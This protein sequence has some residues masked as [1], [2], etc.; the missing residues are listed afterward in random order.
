MDSPSANPPASEAGFAQMSK[1]QKL[2]ALLILLGPETAARLLKGMDEPEMESIT[3]EMAKIGMLSLD[4]QHKVLQEFAELA[5]E[6]ST[7]VAGG[8]DLTHAALERALGSNKA[9]HIMSR[10]VPGHSSS[11]SLQQ[12]TE[13]EP[14]EIFTLVRQEQPQMIALILSYL[15]ADK[16]SAVL[17]KLGENLREDVLERLA[18]LAPTPI[19]VV[20]RLVDMLIG[21]LGNQNKAPLRQSGGVKTAA[22]LLN[23]LDRNLS[24]GLLTS[25]EER[26]PELGQAI[27]Q[28]MFTFED[29]AALDVGSLQKLLREVDTRDLATALKNSSEKVKSSVLGAISKRAAE[30]VREEIGLMGAL[31]ARDIEAAQRRIIEVVRRLESEGELELG[32]ATKK[33]EATV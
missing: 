22:D 10:L 11:A 28:K 21:K 17:A 9:S 8:I 29:V 3:V 24:K 15:S 30:T 6:A 31:K 14:S 19:E 18:T 4:T 27:R 12:L 20:E 23:A 5:V 2:A 13:L 32:D 7:A 1:L 33:D 16:A 25:L 26:N